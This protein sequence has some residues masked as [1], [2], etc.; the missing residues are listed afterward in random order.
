MRAGGVS[1]HGE[2]DLNDWLKF[3]TIT[4]LPQGHEPHADRLR[5]AALSSIVDV[6]AIY[7]NHQFSQEFQLVADKG[8]LQGVAGF[9]YLNAARLRRVRRAAVHDL[10]PAGPVPALPP[11]RVGDVHTKTWAG[12]RATSPTTSRRSGA[13][14]LGGRYTNDKRHAYVLAADLRSAAASP[15]SAAR[16][17]SASGI[18]HCARPRTSTAGATDKAFTPRAS[19]S[20]KPNPNNNL[21]V[22]YSQGFKGGGFDP[23]GQI[24]R[25]RRRRTRQDVYN[26]M[27]F[28]PEKVDSYE[29]GWK[30][31]LFDHRL[32][33][34]TAIFDAEYKDVQVPGSVG[35]TVGGSPDLLRHHHQRRQGA[36]PGRR[37]RDQLSASAENLADGGR[38]AQLC[39]IARLSR[40]ASTST[41][42]AS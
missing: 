39:R 42:S 25:R 9:Y 28:K 26:F 2:V 7:R 33:L 21:Y 11:R 8:P 18:P 37:A 23:R 6:P 22:S 5:R 4:A 24:E 38:P 14:S 40:R 3:R 15:C 41:S 13:L 29:A 32:Q 31:A 1:L 16:H 19:I 17:R 34:A 27:T 10:L 30:A 12:V 35:C 36:L 20:F